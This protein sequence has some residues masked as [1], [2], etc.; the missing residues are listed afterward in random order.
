[1]K[2]ARPDQNQKP[3]VFRRLAMPARKLISR[4]LPK[5]EAIAARLRLFRAHKDA[6]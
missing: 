4:A 5:A 6:T 2:R 3:N 1:M